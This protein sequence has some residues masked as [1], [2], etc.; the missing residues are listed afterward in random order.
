M[1]NLITETSGVENQ[2]AQ[3]GEMNLNIVEAGVE[4]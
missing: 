4:E 1:P 3:G 2:E